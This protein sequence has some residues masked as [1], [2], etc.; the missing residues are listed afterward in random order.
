MR[1]TALFDE[2]ADFRQGLIPGEVGIVD[3]GVSGAAETE[4]VEKWE[5][6]GV[7][8]EHGHERSKRQNEE[9][10]RDE[11]RGGADALLKQAEGTRQRCQQKNQ[12]HDRNSEMANADGHRTEHARRNKYKQEGPDSTPVKGHF[13]WD[14]RRNAFQLASGDKGHE[15]REGEHKQKGEG[16]L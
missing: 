4:V 9:C 13:C 11:S 2:T 6:E 10:G 7:R 12:Q 1:D 14:D 8:A 5:E 16:G 3:H 15:N